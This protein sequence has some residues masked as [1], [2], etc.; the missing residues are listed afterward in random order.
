VWLDSL[1][2]A[3]IRTFVDLTQASDPLQPYE[4]TLQ[5]AAAAR[6]LD[7]TYRRFPV[8]DMGV[9][10]PETMASI[11]SF[12]AGEVA[13]GRKVYLHCLGGV[14]RTGTVAGC[15]LAGDGRDGD[16]ALATLGRL[17]ATTE[18]RALYDT[19]SP[20]TEAQRDFVQSLAFSPDGRV[21]AGRGARPRPGRRLLRRLDHRRPG[22]P[23]QG[24]ARHARVVS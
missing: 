22:G 4:A 5:E 1:L 12:I 6:D 19:V 7:V 21:L 20:Q 10:S 23:V 8:P 3:G 16:D 18:L 11:L 2:D 14:G 15:L 17:F 9:P 13:E 24:P